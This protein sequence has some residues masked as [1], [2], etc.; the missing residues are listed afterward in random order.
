MIEDKKSKLIFKNKCSQSEY[1]ADLFVLNIEFRGI[2]DRD[3]IIDQFQIISEFAEEHKV[4]GTV[5]NLCNMYGS[6]VRLFDFMREFYFPFL[7]EFGLI[8]EAVVVREDHIVR[9][10]GLKWVDMLKEMGLESSIFEDFDEAYVWLLK[11]ITL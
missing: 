3:Q 11:K 9:N 6:P 8:A 4:I 5:S 10:V 2:I 1:N 7:I